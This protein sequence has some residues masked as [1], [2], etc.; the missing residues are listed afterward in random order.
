MRN[1]IVLIFCLLVFIACTPS[2]RITK[3][4]TTSISQLKFLGEYDVPNAKQFKET[5]I[6]GL[7]GIDHD[8]KRDV[9]YLIS[10]D[11][12]A[13]NPARFYTAKI[14]VK[15]SGIDSVEFI[16]VRSLLQKILKL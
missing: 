1:Q 9:Y 12:S 5:T 10:D 16:D 13:I 6:G 14:Y 2:Q 15:E 8:E 7:S 11:R 4:Q 3:T